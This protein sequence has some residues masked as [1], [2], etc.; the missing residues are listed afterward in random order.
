[1][2]AN[3][4]VLD[5][6]CCSGSFMLDGDVARCET[7]KREFEFREFPAFRAERVVSKPRELA[8]E[9]DATCF[10]HAQNQAETVCAGCGRLL[11]AVCA[12]NFGG[13]TL[14]PS[15]IASG[16]TSPAREEK[17][18]WAHA[19]P[20]LLLAT[21]PLIVWPFTLLTAPAALVLTI[22]NWNKPSGVVR[23]FRWQRWV[24]G[25][26]SLAQVLAWAWFFAAM[27]SR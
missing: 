3:P 5:G 24:A 11:C 1:M 16:K 22:V 2:S 10:F 17:E 26:L 9:D 23:R 6:P 27:F 20:A 15:C 8:G 4:P 25:A 13:S 14:C 19:G 21:A 18:K 7:C 12:V